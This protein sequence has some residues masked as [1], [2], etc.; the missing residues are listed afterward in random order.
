MKLI[1]KLTILLLSIIY[2]GQIIAH[3]VPNTNPEDIFKRSEQR[4]QSINQKLMPNMDTQGSS[5]SVITPSSDV[6]HSTVCFPIDK[7]RINV[8]DVLSALRTALSL[9]MIE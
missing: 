8:L 3:N 1:L 5:F 2:S 7:L 6:Y 9:T 4:Q